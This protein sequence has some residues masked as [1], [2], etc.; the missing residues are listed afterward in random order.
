MS[1]DRAIPGATAPVSR[2]EPSR[3]DDAVRRELA[4]T[5][6]RL[7]SALQG[8]QAG[9]WEWNVATG[10]TLFD[11]RWAGIVGYRLADL[12]PVSIQTWMQLAHPDDLAGS[13]VALK[14]VFARELDFYD[15]EAR[16]RHR[17]GH[18]VWVHDRGKVVEWS[19]DGQPRRMIGTHTDITARKVAEEQLRESEARYQAI[20]EK[21][22]AVKL[23][24]DPETGALVDVN[25]A[26][27]R[28][29]GHA[30][31]QMRR[32]HIF[33]LNTLT[34]DE[35]Q[36]EMHRAMV[37][38]KGYFNFRHRLANGDVRDVEVYSSPVHINGRELLNS[39]VHDVTDRRIAEEARAALE[40]QLHQS[41]KAAS[42]ARMAG[43]VAHRFNNRLQAVLGNLELARAGEGE[44]GGPNERI[45]DALQATHDA[46]QL[47]DLML[48][49]L[50]Q[51][52]SRQQNVNL[53][54]FCRERFGA[55]RA[56]LRAGVTL[57]FAGP[58]HSPVVRVDPSQLREVLDHLVAN[59]AESRETGAVRVRI[60]VGRFA[61]TEAAPAIRFPHDWRPSEPAYGCMSVVDDGPGV[62]EGDVE[63]LFDPFFTTKF[64]GRGMGL[65][66]V[67]GHT[68]MN[69]GAIIV[70]TGAHGCAMRVCLPAVE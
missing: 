31:E 65:P 13:D 40:R 12:Q 46:A 66:V 67:L 28:F 36:G 52:P 9:V 5:R 64:T 60:E 4:A 69:G 20:F 37:E 18:W 30:R 38:E 45:D 39:I 61:G 56:S 3:T 43:A 35:V 32:M 62:P 51:K 68:R 8:T 41:E 7:S 10:E 58:A 24:V 6:E 44:R 53:A 70:E 15:V 63:K 47:C 42:L 16:M 55:L 33:D 26:A 27:C 17:D 21:S 50:G 19:A 59:A 54:E 57:E 48:T 1:S 23:L 11:E 25:P 29:Y 49:Y 14:R 34:H 22:R 2:D